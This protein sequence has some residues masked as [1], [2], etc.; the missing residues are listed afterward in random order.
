MVYSDTATALVT[1]RKMHKV[2]AIV[3]IEVQLT[4]SR[5]TH[6][7]TIVSIPKTHNFTHILNSFKL[8]GYIDEKHKYKHNL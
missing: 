6:L 4:C 1:A 8:R 3:A 5:T 7:D 2:S